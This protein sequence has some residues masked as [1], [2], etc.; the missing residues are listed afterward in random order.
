MCYSKKNFIFF[1]LIKQKSAREKKKFKKTFYFFFLLIPKGNTP[2]LQWKLTRL[3]WLPWF[4]HRKR[5]TSQ[6][7]ERKCCGDCQQ[8]LNPDMHIERS[9]R[10]KFTLHK[11]RLNVFFT[12][13]KWYSEQLSIYRNI[14][15]PS[16]LLFINYLIM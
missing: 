3:S 4:Y 13:K 6:N 15:I 16:K 1:Y 14:C 7:F 11:R 8:V 9:I 5:S 12:N 10:R 2:G